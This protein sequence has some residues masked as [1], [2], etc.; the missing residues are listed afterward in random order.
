MALEAILNKTQ[1]VFINTTTQ[2][3]GNYNFNKTY[4]S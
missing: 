4:D 2:I 1:T 3:K